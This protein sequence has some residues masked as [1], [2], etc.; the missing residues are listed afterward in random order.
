MLAD[1][2]AARTLVTTDSE[3]RGFNNASLQDTASVNSETVHRS[4]MFHAHRTYHSHRCLSCCSW[5]VPPF[6]KL[7]RVVQ[8]VG[9]RRR[10]LVGALAKIRGR[11][12]TASIAAGQCSWEGA[13]PL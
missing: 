4:R 7:T 5:D 6:E 11:R 2:Y 1:V 3:T 9:Q 8:P 12:D 10:R 13:H